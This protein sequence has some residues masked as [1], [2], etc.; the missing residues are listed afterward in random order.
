MPAPFLTF[1]FGDRNRT[2][3]FFR[4]PFKMAEIQVI[5]GGFSGLSAA[6]FFMNA[7]HRVRIV[8]TGER[9]GGLL[10][11]LQT[12]YGPVETAANALIANSIVEKTASDL[13]IPLSPAL[14][15]ARR[16]FILRDKKLQRWP[17]R[18]ISSLRLLG[19]ALPLRIIGRSPLLPRP[20]ESVRSW[21]E[22]TIGREATDYLLGPALAGIY[23]SDLDQ[24]SANLTLAKDRKSTRLNSS[25]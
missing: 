25:H 5:G 10:E 9:I 19:I 13:G 14:K 7:G 23:A 11:T 15:T 6:Y 12:P 24:L 8:E 18:A 2:A 1:A 21:G 4:G 20:R 22:R 3:C 17:L 16:C